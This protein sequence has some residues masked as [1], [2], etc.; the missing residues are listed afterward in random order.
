MSDETELT[1]EERE[2]LVEEPNDEPDEGEDDSI[3]VEIAGHDL[4]PDLRG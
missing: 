4:E 2:A 1:E 3:E